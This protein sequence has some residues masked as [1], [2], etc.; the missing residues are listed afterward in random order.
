VHFG[1]DEFAFAKL[2]EYPG[3]AQSRGR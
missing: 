2:C 1:V 3:F